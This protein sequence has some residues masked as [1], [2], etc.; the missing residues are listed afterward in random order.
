MQHNCAYKMLLCEGIV[1]QTSSYTY[2]FSE[3][4]MLL[5]KTV[6]HKI[7]MLEVTQV[8]G[9]VEWYFYYNN[10]GIHLC[11]Y[12]SRAPPTPYQAYKGY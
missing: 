6:Y 7:N 4:A 1:V 3:E 2:I 9:I 10:T 11:T 5:L 8:S 12:Q